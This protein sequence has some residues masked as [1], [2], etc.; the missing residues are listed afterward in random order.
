MIKID[1]IIL[2]TGDNLNHEKFGEKVA[3]LSVPALPRKGDRVRYLIDGEPSAL[4]EVT[5]GCFDERAGKKCA[6][7]VFGKR[8]V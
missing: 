1:L 7:M 5:D 2:Q 6:V 3:T 8:R 4:L